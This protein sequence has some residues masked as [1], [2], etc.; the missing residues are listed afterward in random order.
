[1]A[2]LEV[3]DLSVYYGVIQ[4]LKGISFQ[5]NEGE[6]VTLIVLTVQ[7]KLLQCKVL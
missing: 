5:V 3:K 1:M 6:I 2:L 7:V 4:A